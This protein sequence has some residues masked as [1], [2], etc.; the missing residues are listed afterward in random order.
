MVHRLVILDR[1]GCINEDSPDYIRSPDEWIPIPGSIEA[2]ARLKHAGFTV[3]VATNQSGLAR[4]Y[5][6]IATLEAMHAKLR[7]LLGAMNADVDYIAHCPHG[8]DEGCDCRKPAPGLYREIS[9]ALRMPLV[10]VPVIG[11]SRR[12][13]EAAAAVGAQ[14]LLVLTGKGRDTM[15]KGRLPEG[16]RVYDNLAQAADALIAEQP[17]NPDPDPTSRG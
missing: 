8:P 15:K 2:I 12:D 7:A 9:D 16:T 13:L 14:P 11:D 10:G 4:G 17:L 3:A 6:D 5:F 1:D